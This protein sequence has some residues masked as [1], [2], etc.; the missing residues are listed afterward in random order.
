MPDFRSFSDRD[1]LHELLVNTA[2]ASYVRNEWFRRLA[3][4]KKN[5]HIEDY[6]IA[7]SS[8][9]K[10]AKELT[11]IASASMKKVTTVV[12]AAV[13]ENLSRWNE[14]AELVNTL[15]EETNMRNMAALFYDIWSGSDPSGRCKKT[16]KEIRDFLAEQQVGRPMLWGEINNGTSFTRMWTLVMDTFTRAYNH[17]MKKG[18]A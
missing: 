7:H 4:S 17:K 2:Q 14:A 10:K 5:S 3:T 8:A 11:D 15:N 13:K 16:P 18:A 6:V 9:F 12:E 1:L